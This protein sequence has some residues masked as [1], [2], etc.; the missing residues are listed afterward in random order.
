MSQKT[1]YHFVANPG[2]M[3][4]KVEGGQEVSARTLYVLIDDSVDVK[5]GPLGEAKAPVVVPAAGGSEL[6]QLKAIGWDFMSH[7]DGLLYDRAGNLLSKPENTDP[8]PAEVMHDLR[9]DGVG[10]LQQW[11]QDHPYFHNGIDVD[12]RS[13]L[14]NFPGDTNPHA[15][16]SSTQKP[17]YLVLEAGIV[18]PAP[19]PVA[20]V[21]VATDK[22]ETIVNAPYPQGGQARYTTRG[23]EGDRVTTFVTQVPASAAK[24]G[25]YGVI[26][27]AEAPGNPPVRRA[28]RIVMNG[29]EVVPFDSI[30]IASPRYTFSMGETLPGVD[31][32][33][34]VGELA[35]SVKNLDGDRS[36]AL[37]EPAF[38]AR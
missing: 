9:H 2:S 21:P 27:F 23:L 4:V 13:D 33:C 17:G 18:A 15:R 6:A 32:V 38:P 1:E 20:V 19:V 34:E 26:P 30:G 7:G 14:V 3:S 28:V 16:Y 29:R 37:Y 12:G 11:K 31:F 8:L 24:A 22:T 36:E 35:V 25:S 5:A 10:A